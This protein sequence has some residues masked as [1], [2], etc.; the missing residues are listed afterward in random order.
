MRLVGASGVPPFGLDRLWWPGWLVSAVI[1]I[2]APF[3]FSSYVTFVLSLAAT[4]A[5]GA[6]GLTILVGWTGQLSLGHSAF[7]ALGAFVSAVLTLRLGLPF[8]VAGPLGALATGL[9]GIGLGIPLVR[10]SGPYLALATFGLAAAVPELILNWSLISEVLHLGVP[11]L[12]GGVTGLKPPRPTLL[13]TPL[14]S[15]RAFYFIVVLA[16]G[17]AILGALNIRRS[18][19]GRAMLAL[20]DSPHAALAYGLDVARYRVWAFGIAALYAGVAGTLYGAL[21]KF[22]TPASFDLLQAIFFVAAVVVGG[23]GSIAGAL[24]GVLLLTF[25]TEA[26]AG[27]P[28]GVQVF[29]GLAIILVA[30]FTRGGLAGLVTR[31]ILGLRQARE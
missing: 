10:L 29:Y 15:E 3:V 11:D 23:V 28:S 7:V 25:V 24:G 2:A 22:I 21:V 6:I 30:M 16:L 20:R 14:E 5:I 9:L 17:A 19:T 1:V 31:V 26:L 12:F 13:G 8:W 18:R 27:V 4:Y